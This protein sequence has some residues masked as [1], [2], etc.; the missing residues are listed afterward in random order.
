MSKRNSQ[1]LTIGAWNSP[2]R[3]K[4]RGGLT[5]VRNRAPFL[6]G[7]LVILTFSH[8]Y[9]IGTF[10]MWGGCF[11]SVDCLMIWYRQK[12]DPWNAVISGF[13]T[14]GMLAIRGG[15]NVAFKNAL[16]GGVIL[17]LIE[18]ISIII[19]AVA[20]RRQHMMMMHAMKMEREMQ[21]QQALVNNS[22]PWEVK[23]DE[24]EATGVSNYDKNNQRS[25]KSF[26]F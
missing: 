24:G 15:A 2:R 23:F 3:M 9:A 6:G 19:Q 25:A 8:Q 7:T 12:D 11:S 10:A 13:V 18:G 5:H 20:M 22:D 26:S 4:I 16:M 21:K 17:G 14:G 1:W